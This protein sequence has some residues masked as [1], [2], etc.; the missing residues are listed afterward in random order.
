MRDIKEQ[1]KLLKKVRLER[2]KSQFEGRPVLYFSYLRG[3]FKKNRVLVIGTI[4]LL[5]TQGIIETLLVVLSRNQLGSSS[6]QRIATQS[7]WPILT[8]LIILYIINSFLSIKQE[9]TVVVLLI[10][11]LRRRIFK[12]YLGQTIEE[13]KSE[14]KAD[15]I[16]KISY[17]LPLVSMGLSNAFFGAIRWLIYLISALVVTWLAG[18]SLPIILAAFIS[19]SLL[20]AIPAYFTVRRYV[21]QE[22]TFYSQ[23]IKHIDFSLS[24]K[25]FLKSYNLEPETISKFD[26]L[27]NFDSIFRVRRDIWMKM[28]FKLLFALLLVISLLTHIFHRG[29]TYWIN[30]ISPELRFLYAFLLIYL[31]R[32]ATESLR[33]GLYL[34]P[35]KLGLTLSILPVRKYSHRQNRLNIHQ[36]IVFYSRK[37]KLTPLGQ[38]YHDLRLELRRGGRYLIYGPNRLGKTALAKLLIGGKIHNPNAVKVRIDGQRLD[39]QEYQRSFNNVY[40]FDPNFYSQKSLMEIILGRNREN[41]SFPD[42]EQALRIIREQAWLSQLVSADNNYSLAAIDIWHNQVSAFAL[43]ALHCLVTQPTLM[44]IDNAWLDL[45]YPDIHRIISILSQELP[46]AIIVLL[47]NQNNHILNY[48]QS[49]SLVEILLPKSAA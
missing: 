29:L 8:G 28:G 21:S 2:N 22:V 25:Y 31:S 9:K 48:D 49:F 36:D 32:V 18:L 7:F 1:I 40:Y 30:L 3:F 19:L 47:A 39:F 38:Y 17:H 23:I 13:M 45:G 33:I 11:N 20:I 27:V 5:I 16:A 44:V 15:L 4:F 6:A 14:Q 41:S 26:R 42:I 35:A 10:N 43:Q 46:S 37:N 34:F 12:D 24:E